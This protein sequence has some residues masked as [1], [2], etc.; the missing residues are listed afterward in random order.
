M[1]KD[2]IRVAVEHA[3]IFIERAN[4]LLERLDNEDG[5]ILITGCKESAA[6]RRQSMELTR[7]LAEL[8]KSR[9]E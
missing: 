4:D 1:N 3:S 2:R 6:L 5:A 8:R 9:V 7:A